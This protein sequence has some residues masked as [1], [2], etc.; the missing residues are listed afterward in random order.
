MGEVGNEEET[1]DDGGAHDLNLRS[2]GCPVLSICE[3]ATRGTCAV[4]TKSSAR[5]ASGVG[6]S[7]PRRAP[8]DR[9]GARARRPG[10]GVDVG[11]G[12]G[13]RA[14][15]AT[16]PCRRRRAASA[17]RSAAHRLRTPASTS[18]R[19]P[20]SRHPVR[21]GGERRARSRAATTPSP[22]RAPK[23]RRAARRCQRPPRRRCQGSA[24][25]ARKMHAPNDVGF[26]RAA[27][28]RTRQQRPDDVRRR[29]ASRC[30]DHIHAT[31]GQDPQTVISHA[32]ARSPLRGS[33]YR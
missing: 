32:I 11:A 30:E 20:L 14:G 9:S 13:A 17:R 28:R 19:G 25:R 18:R 7:S 4:I 22:I 1:D 31:V 23:K 10:R 24:R 27:G 2:F 6:P 16:G 5:S 12:S 33:H 26:W 29:P 15:A 8:R 3:P 21:E